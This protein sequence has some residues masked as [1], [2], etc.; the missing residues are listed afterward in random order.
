VQ[1][2]GE[3]LWDEIITKLQKFK[4]S[5]AVKGSFIGISATRLKQGESLSH[6]AATTLLRNIENMC[7]VKVDHPV[8]LNPD[9][10]AAKDSSRRALQPLSG[11]PRDH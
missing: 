1:A 10:S 8:R 5:S 9:R 11:R 7:P 6:P 4:V 3:D 2:A